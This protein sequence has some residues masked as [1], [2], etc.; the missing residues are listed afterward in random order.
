MAVHIQVEPNYVVVHSNAASLTEQE[1]QN[2]V[3]AVKTQL[4][5]RPLVVFDF[6]AVQKTTEPALRTLTRAVSEVTQAE[7]KVA[8]VVQKPIAQFI[9]SIG[10]DRLFPCF[11]SI[12]EAV[13]FSGATVAKEHTLEFLNTTL[14]AVA[15]TLK[16]ATSTEVSPGKSHVRSED[17]P[18]A[19]AVD[20]GASVG[21]VSAPFNGTLIL[22]FPLKT[23]LALMS[24]LL[25]KEYA[26]ID[27]SIRDGAAE[28]LNII[29]GQ[30]RATLNE[31]GYAIKQAIPTVVYGSN[32]QI[33]NFSNTPSVIV[34]YKSDAGDFYIELTTRPAQPAH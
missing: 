31:K 28:L 29:L 4:D 22:A 10:L 1:A 23:Y 7:A 32:L 19:P 14:E 27:A 18:T 33:F 12:D 24:R 20:I 34:P 8:M 9:T 5:R 6:T 2:C 25:G 15:Y 13:N 11:A 30:A 21:I 17:S 16:V 26:E 3:N